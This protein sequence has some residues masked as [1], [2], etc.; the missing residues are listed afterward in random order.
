MNARKKF[1]RSHACRPYK[2]NHTRAF[3]ID[4]HLLKRHIDVGLITIM[5]CFQFKD[6]IKEENVQNS[7]LMYIRAYFL[8]TGYIYF[9]ILTVS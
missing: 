8:T 6:F 9:N 3:K 5:C 4:F 2:N 7:H 1:P